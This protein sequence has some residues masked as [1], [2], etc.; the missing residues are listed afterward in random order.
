MQRT[1]PNT[2]PAVMWARRTAPGQDEHRWPMDGVFRHV[3]GR[4]CPCRPT[5]MHTHD[6]GD[7][8]VWYHRPEVERLSVPNA[9]PTNL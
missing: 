5:L 6:E 3:P 2:R 4:F 7:T 1:S 9:L 8:P